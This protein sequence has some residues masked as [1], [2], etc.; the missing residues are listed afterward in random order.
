MND[1]MQKIVSLCKRRGFVFPGSEIYN[2]LANT[3]DWGPLGAQLVKNIK[4]LWWKRFVES[5]DDIVPIQSDILM[6]SK[7]WQASGHLEGFT[8]PLIECK[9]CKKRFREDQLREQVGDRPLGRDESLAKAR[10]PD[11]LQCPECN[12]QLDSP[13]QFNLMFKTFI[14]P[15]EDK[16]STVYL[17]PE[18]AQGMFVNFKNIQQSMRAKLPFGIAQIG[19]AFRNEITPG[20]F[21]FRVLEFEQME[22]EYFIREQDWEKW[23]AHWQDQMQKWLLD[24]GIKKQSFKIREHGKDELSHYSKKTIDFEYKYPFGQK[25]LYGLAYR[26]DF[27]LKAHQSASG[28]S[29]EFQDTET[30]KKFIP[31][32]IEPTFGVERTVLALLCDAYE[33][34]DAR[35]GKGDKSEKEIVLHLNPKIAPIKAA[36]LPLVKNKKEITKT[37]RDIHTILKNNF[38]IQ[39]DETGSIGKRYRRQDE[40]GT[41]YC[42]TVDFETLK[43]NSATI[44]ERD[45]LKQK[46]INIPEINDYLEKKINC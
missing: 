22:I 35:S 31:H 27:D 3:W 33:E 37:A 45:T 39:Y 36:I 17:R 20:N 40:I 21:I 1:K 12:S 10:T 16:T 9:K 8:D 2:G 15:L 13:R 41:P 24:I 46:R 26:T 19:K 32:V 4:D 42:I 5:R 23:F 18:T 43:D 28:Q 30:C 6:N 7:V 14:G 38:M 44:R 29:L 11:M 25:E 34:V